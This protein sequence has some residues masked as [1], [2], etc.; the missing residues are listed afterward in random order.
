MGIAWVATGD[1]IAGAAAAAA[2]ERDAVADIICVLVIVCFK[3]RSAWLVKFM[4]FQNH[5]LVF[6]KSPIFVISSLFAFT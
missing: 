3:Q 5:N 1:G 4:I 6:T 2:K